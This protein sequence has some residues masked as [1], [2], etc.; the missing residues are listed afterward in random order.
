MKHAS[1]LPQKPS[2][3]V[4]NY[5]LRDINT[6][7]TVGDDW[8]LRHKHGKLMMEMQKSPC[9]SYSWVVI[10]PQSTEQLYQSSCIKASIT[11]KI[12]QNVLPNN[13]IDLHVVWNHHGVSGHFHQKKKILVNINEM[14]SIMTK[15]CI[16][17]TKTQVWMKCTNQLM[18][19][20]SN[21]H[22]VQLTSRRCPWLHV[23]V[24]K[25]V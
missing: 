10:L 13:F 24:H 22:T 4:S 1:T 23:N 7:C 9:L 11:L 3:Y 2:S 16:F 18:W 15:R 17:A 25:T 8:M 14:V 12:C 6:I 20:Y 19:L 21:N 5:K